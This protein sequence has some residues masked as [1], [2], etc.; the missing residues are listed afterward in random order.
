MRTYVRLIVLALAVAGLL[1]AAPASAQRTGMG[2]G[3]AQPNAAARGAQAPQTPQPRTYLTVNP[4]ELNRFG[5]RFKDSY[6]AVADYFGDFVP[7]TQFPQDLIQFGVTPASFILFSTQRAMG[8]NMLVIAPRN[9]APIAAVFA[10]PLVPESPIYLQGKVGPRIVLDAGPMTLFYADLIVRGHKP[11]EAQK[12]EEKRPAKIILEWEAGSTVLKREYKIP[13][14]GM[15]YKIPDPH[16]PAKDIY[17]T[18]E[19]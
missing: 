7:E 5:E 9:S 1:V 2:A 13:E 6:V 8:S 4:A 15:R 17:I 14:P 11:P 12:T 16:D 3:A 19:Y 10:A 18:L